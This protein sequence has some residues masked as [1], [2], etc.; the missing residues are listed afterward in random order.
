M[1]QDTLFF[2]MLEIKVA[3][4]ILKKNYITVWI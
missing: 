4:S 2:I 1:Q 3:E